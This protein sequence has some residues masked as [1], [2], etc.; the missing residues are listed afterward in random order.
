[1]LNHCENKSQTCAEHYVY[2]GVQKT[3]M[4]YKYVCAMTSITP[5]VDQCCK[6]HEYVVLFRTSGN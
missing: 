6:V 4:K 2:E 1:M 3:W 5:L